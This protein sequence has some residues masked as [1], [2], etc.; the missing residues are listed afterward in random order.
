MTS[1]PTDPGERLPVDRRRR[2]LLRDRSA[3]PMRP[4]SCSVTAPVAITRSGS[5]R[6]P[7]SRPTT[8]SSRGTSAASA[9]R[10][11]AT[12]SRIREPRPSDLLAILDQLGVE[13]A[14]VVGQ[15]LGG[16]AAMGLAIAHADRVRTP[17]AR[18]HAGRHPGRRLVEGRA[19]RH[20]RRGRSTI[21]R[22]RTSSAVRNPERAHLYLE[23]GGLRRDPNADPDRA[24]PDAGRRDLRRRATRR[25]RAADPVHR[26][27]RRRDLPARLDRRR[28]R[29]RARARGS[30]RSRAPGTRRTSS[31]PT[32]GTP[33][34]RTS[35]ANRRDD[36]EQL[37]QG[38]RILT[39]TLER[40]TPRTSGV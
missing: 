31:S 20:A 6:C 9:T 23:I 21:P 4:S 18:R 34:S 14:H 19:T 38:P 36:G 12:G 13:R 8:A 25:A 5:N 2:R 26:G 33:W 32:C 30:R 24:D 16:W 3:R 7:C 10:R 27:H 29:A 15:S 11:T 28:G 39:R 35:G 17:R 22:C 37:S 1:T 40:V